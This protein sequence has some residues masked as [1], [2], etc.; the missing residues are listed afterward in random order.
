M[1][2]KVYSIIITFNPTITEILT[3]IQN[4]IEKNDSKII[5]VDNGSEN[6]EQ[7]QKHFNKLSKNTTKLFYYH[8]LDKNYGIGHAL[9]E[10]VKFAKANGATHVLF[11]DQ[12]SI[13]CNNIVGKLISEEEILMAKGLKLGALG[14]V[15]SDSRTHI[16]YPLARIKGVNLKKIW[17]SKQKEKTFEVSFIITSGSLIKLNIITEVGQ[18]DENFFIDLVDFE[19]CFRAKSKGYKIFATK[20]AK[21]SHS[22]GDKR[23][24]SLGREISIHS[25]LRRYYMVR[26][27]ILLA[28]KKY[29]PFGYRMRIIFGIIFRT[30]RILFAVKWSPNYLKAIA[31]GIKD[32]ILNR[33]GFYNG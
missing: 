29:V 18:F 4:H 13:P 12:D 10:G 6:A 17:P 30:P 28:R 26:N 20:A 24:M 27:N 5:I 9:N 1:H 16:E 25:P 3:V 15:Y 2:H 14:P 33:G 19:W 11:F 23:I 32:G 22:I 8:Q 7:I 21:I 31:R